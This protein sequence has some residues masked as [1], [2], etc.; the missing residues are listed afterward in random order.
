[1]STEATQTLFRFTNLRNPELAQ[2]KGNYGFISRPKFLDDL[3]GEGLGFFDQILEEKTNLDET[4]IVY[5]TSR[6]KEYKNNPSYV[7]SIDDLGKII[8]IEYFNSI[9]IY[10]DEYTPGMIRLTEG[11]NKLWDNLIYQVLTEENFYLKEKIVEI[12]KKEHYSNLGLYQNVEGEIKPV[13]GIEE[14]EFRK[15]KAREAKIVLPEE[16]F[17]ESSANKKRLSKTAKSNPFQ[18]Q[19]LKQ[20]AEKELFLSKA[21]ADKVELEQLKSELKKAQS[22]YNKGYNKALKLAQDTYQK[23]IQLEEEAYSLALLETEAN[24]PSETTEA[25]RKLALTKVSKPNFPDFNFQ[26]TEQLDTTFLENKLSSKTRDTLVDV[27]RLSDEFT[28]EN[29]P[30]SLEGKTSDSL[31]LDPNEYETLADVLIAVENKIKKQEELIISHTEVEQDQYVNI[32]GVFLP[33]NNKAANSLSYIITP[34][35]KLNNRVSF[36]LFFTVKDPSLRVKSILYTIKNRDNTNSNTSGYYDVNY[37]ND[38]IY[39]NNLYNTGIEKGNYLDPIIDI[40]IK[41][42]DGQVYYIKQANLSFNEVSSGYFYGNGPINDD[43]PTGSFDDG[44]IPSGFG[45]RRLGI[46]DYLKIEQSTH[47]YVPGEVAHIENIMAREYREKST[48]RTRRTEDTTTSSSE[49]EREQL[50]DTTTATRFDMQTEIAKMMAETTDAATSVS[51]NKLAVNMGASF[52]HNRSKDESSRTAVTQAKDIT[53]R[54]LDRIVSKVKDERVRKVVEEFEESNMHGFDNRKGDKNVVGV[55]RWVDKI[56]KNQIF[57]YGKRLTFEFMI[58]QPSKINNLAMSSGASKPKVLDKPIDPRISKSWNLYLPSI[59]ENPSYESTHY[60]SL[61]YWAGVYNVEI[62]DQLNFEKKVSI[63][64]SDKDLGAAEDGRWSGSYNKEFEVEEQY[65]VKGIEGSIFLGEGHYDKGVSPKAIVLLNGKEVIKQTE[66]N[67]RNIYNSSSNSFFRINEQN[68]SISDKISLSAQFYD[69]KTLSGSLVYTCNLTKE[70]LSNELR[71][72]YNQIISAYEEALAI[73]EEKVSQSVPEDSNIKE[74]NANFYRQIESDVLRH[75]CMAYLVDPDKLGSQLYTGNDLFDFSI[76]KDEGMD[77]YASLVKFMEQAF[78]WDIMSYN[79]YPYYWGSKTEWKDLYQA[80]S[81]DPLFRSF[82][83]SGM[84][85]VVVTVKPGFEDAVQFYMS[86]GRIWNGGEVPVIGDPM[87]ISLVE[88]MREPV[89]DKVGKF[90]LTKLPTSLN[91]LQAESIGL[92]VEQALP[93]TKEIAAECE[94]PEMIVEKA[95]FTTTKS[96]LNGGTTTGGDSG[97][98]VEVEEV[99]SGDWTDTTSVD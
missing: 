53:D 9:E 65:V 21:K 20:K 30:V 38:G 35:S 16:L 79:F 92:T 82:L 75:N 41:F 66:N 34:N 45:V 83:Q 5:L 89:G 86:T 26:Y 2:T 80:E 36:N 64:F 3:P 56:M 47:A 33:V 51:S 4:K 85:R 72:V 18:L 23:S 17:V 96:L 71:K 15:K 54:A 27:I 94:N 91:V 60:L 28:V 25:Q 52:A 58:P 98:I 93:F 40:E 14:M 84:A 67:I 12:L 22:D 37:I 59:L 99:I 7:S 29:D 10:D 78:E 95:P 77:E 81:I 55:Y 6:A 62:N 57:N 48:R 87:Y 32:G 43:D 19:E 44:F 42:L 73:F 49:S 11:L 8:D 61:K 68:L 90:W 76:K 97:N 24:L 39:I 46:A 1:M 13:F 31:I 69:V 50:T 74:A 70:Y 63:S 88:E